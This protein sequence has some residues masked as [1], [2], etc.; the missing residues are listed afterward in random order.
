[1]ASLLRVRTEEERKR[2]ARSLAE[3]SLV[4]RGEQYSPWDVTERAHVIEQYIVVDA[5]DRRAANDEI[6]D[7]SS[8]AAEYPLG[9]NRP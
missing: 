6:H 1:M 9:G 2:L 7:A 5:R 3:A 8:G 4:R